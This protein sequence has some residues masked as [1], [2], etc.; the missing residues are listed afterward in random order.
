VLAEAAARLAQVSDMLS[1]FLAP[2]RQQITGYRLDLPGRG[3]AFAP[4]F[5]PNRW[6]EQQVTGTV[7]LGRYYLGGNGAA[8]G[9]AVPLLFDEVM[10]RLASTGRKPART[11]YLHVN[12][13]AITP[14]DT[15]LRLETHF[16][17]EEGRKR[18]LVGTLYH[19]DVLCADAEAL[20]VELR[21]G[22]P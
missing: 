12:F 9:G 16:D 14:I 20:F 10:G 13:R 6:D 2:E 17:R 3:Q 11:A 4:V 1:A 18:F 21:P 22:Q 5:E 15:E 8:H 19:G 7:T